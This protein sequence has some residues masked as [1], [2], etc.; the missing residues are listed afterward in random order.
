MSRRV[1]I[2]LLK[3][4][5][6][7]FQLLHSNNRFNLLPSVG[8]IRRSQSLQVDKISNR[9]VEEILSQIRDVEVTES[10][11]L[12]KALRTNVLFNGV[13]NFTEDSRF[14]DLCDI[15]ER[16]CDSM[17]PSVLVSG[18][19]SLLEVG[20]PP[21]ATC[22]VKAEQRILDTIRQ[23]S[24]FNLIGCLYYHHKFTQTTLQKR[25]VEELVSQIHQRVHEISSPAEVLMLVHVHHLLRDDGIKPVEM[26]IVQLVPLMKTQEMF[27]L[28]GTMGEKS[29]RNV[30]ILNVVVYHLMRKAQRPGFKEMIDLLYVFKKLN[31]YDPLLYAYLLNHLP[32]EIPS[33][34]QASLI[35]GLLTVCGHLR[36][37]HTG[38]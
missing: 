12:L 29:I 22:V 30:A 2:S 15:F 24:T 14:K 6:K 8:I 18:L 1:S 36:W 23:F 7:Q 13:K 32:A 27:K 11:S 35:S 19:R 5:S 21:T 34:R 28:L 33:V 17:T 37:R 31:F 16:N 26:K 25:V 4:Y 9:P 38:K 10:V 3:N 20:L